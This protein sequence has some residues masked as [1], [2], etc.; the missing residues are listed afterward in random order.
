MVLVKI[1]GSEVGQALSRLTFVATQL[2]VRV[3]PKRKWL[4]H[5]QNDVDDPRGKSQL[6]PRTKSGQWATLNKAEEVRGL[7]FPSLCTVGTH[8]SMNP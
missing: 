3:R 6:G 7:A 1:R 4:A 2:Y 5:A 8:Y